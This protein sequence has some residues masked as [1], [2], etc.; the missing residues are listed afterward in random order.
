MLL[1][2]EEWWE[3]GVVEHYFDHGTGDFGDKQVV[4]RN[5]AQREEALF[6]R[7]ERGVHRQS[8]AVLDGR[9]TVQSDHCSAK[10][11]NRS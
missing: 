11:R 7:V 5:V 10:I 2:I 9:R 1:A 8:Q 6:E 3:S 4:G